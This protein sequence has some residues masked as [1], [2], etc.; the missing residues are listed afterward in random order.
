VDQSVYW[1]APTMHTVSTGHVHVHMRRSRPDSTEHENDPG[2]CL[3]SRANG[4]LPEKEPVFEAN[5]LIP[6]VH[7]RIAME[8]DVS[9]RAFYR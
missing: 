7:T 1:Q 5:D 9:P 4:L 2:S 8:H 6:P 3:A